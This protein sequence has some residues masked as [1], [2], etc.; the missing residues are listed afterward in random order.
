[1]VSGIW[2]LVS[3]IWYLVSGIW[4]LVFGIWYIDIHRTVQIPNTRYF[5]YCHLLF[6]LSQ[7]VIP[8]LNCTGLRN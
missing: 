6:F 1:M 8:I 3:G 5:Y 2:Y 7:L 4:Y